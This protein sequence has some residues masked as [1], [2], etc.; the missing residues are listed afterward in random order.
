MK[1]NANLRKAVNVSLA[2]LISASH[3]AGAMEG[4]CQREGPPG[5]SSRNN[6]ETI[7]R[8]IEELTARIRAEVDKVLADYRRDTAE[9]HRRMGVRDRE[10]PTTMMLETQEQEIAQGQIEQP[11]RGSGKVGIPKEC[12]F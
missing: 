12:L 4:D 11:H 8:E 10:W 2:L 5:L 6:Y 9:Y 1:N 7:L 3:A